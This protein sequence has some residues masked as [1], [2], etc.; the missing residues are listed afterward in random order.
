MVER[1]KGK[2]KERREVKGERGAKWGGGRGERV[3]EV[4]SGCVLERV[5]ERVQGLTLFE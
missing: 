1:I 3:E 5:W 4:F 2:R